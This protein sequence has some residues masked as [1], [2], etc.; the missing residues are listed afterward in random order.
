MLLRLLPRDKSSMRNSAILKVLAIFLLSLINI[1]LFLAL[2]LCFADVGH[3]AESEKYDVTIQGMIQETRGSI[4][5]IP[6]EGVTMMGRIITDYQAAIKAHPGEF[7][8]YIDSPG[9]EIG[10]AGAQFLKAMEKDG[11]DGVKIRCVVGGMAASL[12]MSIFSRCTER[13]MRPE[14]KLMWH[15][16][17]IMLQPNTQLDELKAKQVVKYLSELNDMVWAPLKALLADAEG[18][19]AACDQEYIWPASQLVR[20]YPQMGKVEPAPTP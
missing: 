15:S 9:G 11:A 4:F 12:A 2:M 7:S 8:I 20:A 19:Q 3:S 16:A 10:S 6:P 18:F 1:M 13:V 5:N 14:A 17:R